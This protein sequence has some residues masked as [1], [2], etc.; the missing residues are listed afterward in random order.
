MRREDFY[1]RFAEVSGNVVGRSRGIW[2]DQGGEDIKTPEHEAW[3][4]IEPREVSDLTPATP[5]Y[6]PLL[7]G[8]NIA[9]VPL[10]A[11]ELPVALP[12]TR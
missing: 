6:C 2:G 8:V 9:Q 4:K 12:V 5:H 7:P 1:P 10:R 3:K 11:P